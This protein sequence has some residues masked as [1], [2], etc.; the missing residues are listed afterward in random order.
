[1]DYMQEIKKRAK[2]LE[3]EV[4]DIFRDDEDG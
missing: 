3:E 1:M 4:E 2:A